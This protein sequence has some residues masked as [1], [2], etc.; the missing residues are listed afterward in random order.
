MALTSSA[1]VYQDALNGGYGH[2]AAGLAALTATL[3][4]YGIMMNNEVGTWFLDKTV[5]YSEKV[6]RQVIK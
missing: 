5:G 1:D 3:G 4:Q 6:N 2:R